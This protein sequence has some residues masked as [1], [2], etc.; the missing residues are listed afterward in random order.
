MIIVLIGW[1]L[2]QKKMTRTGV[3][4]DPLDQTNILASSEHCFRSKFVLF[5]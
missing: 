1:L 4:N 2:C 3:I 5:C